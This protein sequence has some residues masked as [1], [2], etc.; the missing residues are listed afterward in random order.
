MVVTKWRV[1]RCSVNLFPVAAMTK[2]HRLGFWRQQ[3]FT[4]QP[5]WRPDVGNQWRQALPFPLLEAETFPGSWFHSSDL[6]SVFMWLLPWVSWVSNLLRLFLIR[7]LSLDWHACLL[8]RFNHVWLFATPRAITLQAPLSMGVSR[9]GSW[10]GL[11][12]PLSG[13]LPD[14]GIEPGSSA[15]QA[16]YI[17]LSHQQNPFFVF[18]CI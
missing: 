1:F 10:S 4:L 7:L 2:Q 14:P 12:C 15:L 5:S 3:A 18:T 13:D 8:S 11:P 6:C 9:Q 16:G 17:P